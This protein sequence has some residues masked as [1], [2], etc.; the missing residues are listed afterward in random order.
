MLEEYFVKPGTVDRIRAAWIGPQIEQ[1]VTWLAGQAM[2][3]GACGGGCR[4]WRL[5]GSS[6]A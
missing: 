3:P 5:S 1:Y 4:S 2:A 6:P